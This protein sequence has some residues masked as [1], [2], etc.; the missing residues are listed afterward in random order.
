ME[1]VTGRNPGLGAAP[2][3]RPTWVWPWARIVVAY[4]LLEWALWSADRRMQEIASLVFIAWIVITTVLQRRSLR[5]L[6]LGVSGM[7]DAAIAIPI[8]LLAAVLILFVAWM[9]GTL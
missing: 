9:F 8:S 4:A 1:K 2:G 3:V 7:R 5:D 6:G